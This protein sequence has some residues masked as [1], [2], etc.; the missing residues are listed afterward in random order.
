M[1]VKVL[2]KEKNELEL[3]FD[4][5]TFPE[6]LR[7]YL[8]KDP[9]VTFAAWKKEHATMNPSILVKTKGKDAKAVLEHAVSEIIKDLEKVESDFK[10][11]K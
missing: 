8:N 1:E 9:A 7:V 3:E 11:L 5:L 10:A 6:I 4:N 2:K